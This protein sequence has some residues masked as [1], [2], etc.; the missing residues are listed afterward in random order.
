MLPDKLHQMAVSLF[1]YLPDKWVKGEIN[2]NYSIAVPIIEQSIE[3][4]LPEYIKV[5]INEKQFNSL[6]KAKEAFLSGNAI[7]ADT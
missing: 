7:C 4:K 1:P 2:N 6:K 5:T 3:D